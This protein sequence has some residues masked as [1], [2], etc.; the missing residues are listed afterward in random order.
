MHAAVKHCSSLVTKGKYIITI[1]IWP[2]CANFVPRF[3]KLVTCALIYELPKDS[4]RG[5]MSP[6]G[7]GVIIAIY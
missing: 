6:F 1:I 4:V 3:F 7:G 5:A 2:K